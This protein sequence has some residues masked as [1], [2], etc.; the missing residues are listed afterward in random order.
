MTSFLN[1]HHIRIFDY[2]RLAE[3]LRDRSIK[4]FNFFDKAEHSLL[5][6]LQRPQFKIRGVRPADLKPFLPQLSPT[7]I[8]RYLKRLRDFGLIKKVGGTYRYN[9]TRIGRSAIAASCR[10]SEQIIAPTL[11]V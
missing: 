5:C 6:S 7:S 3:P 9:L 8:T 2:P 1:A 4:E 10:L 11:T